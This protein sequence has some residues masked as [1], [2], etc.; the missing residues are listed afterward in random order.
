MSNQTG[1]LAT[2]LNPGEG[3][4]NLSLPGLVTT[5]QNEESCVI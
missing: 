5:M 3:R 2:A 4:A 1:E